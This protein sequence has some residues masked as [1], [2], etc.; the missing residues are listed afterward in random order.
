[1]QQKN[2]QGFVL[3]IR[4]ALIAAVLSMTLLSLP[5]AALDIYG[6]E[7]HI[8]DTFTE[9]IDEA[10]Q[11]VQLQHNVLSQW[12]TEVNRENNPLALPKIL[13]V[14]STVQ[15]NVEQLTEPLHQSLENS[16]LNQG[17]VQPIFHPQTHEHPLL[18]PKKPLNYTATHP[19]KHIFRPKLNN[20]GLTGISHEYSNDELKQKG[21]KFYAVEFFQAMQKF[22]DEK[23]TEIAPKLN[24]VFVFSITKEDEK[25]DCMIDLKNSP[26]GVIYFDNEA[27]QPEC[28][29][30]MTD[31]QLISICKKELS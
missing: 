18:R 14:P 20:N 3:L 6:K 10:R 7:N 19:H 27:I 21:K 4:I 1:M 9:Q 8:Y 31:S 24:S 12:K 22:L 15:N 13:V 17:V 26:S 30:E 11:Y 28:T 2:S 29:I 16:R 25:L 5:A 23:G